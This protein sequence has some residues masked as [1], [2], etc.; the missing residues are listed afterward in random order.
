MCTRERQRRRAKNE[1]TSSGPP[2]PPG[3][4]FKQELAAATG[5]AHT[6]VHPPRARFC[7]LTSRAPPGNLGVLVMGAA[8]QQ[9]SLNPWQRCCCLHLRIC[10]RGFWSAKFIWASACASGEIDPQGGTSFYWLQH[11]VYLQIPYRALLQQSSQIASCAV[12]DERWTSGLTFT[13]FLT[14]GRCSVI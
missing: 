8:V 5:W 2:G 6:D 10:C 9:K 4:V 7:P 3:Q 14:S 11:G 13:V 1:T 12:L